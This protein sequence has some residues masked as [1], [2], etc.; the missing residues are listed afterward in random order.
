MAQG[1]ILT[2]PGGRQQVILPGEEIVSNPLN[3]YPTAFDAVEPVNPIEADWQAIQN[4]PITE[5][6]AFNDYLDGGPMPTFSQP[7]VSPITKGATVGALSR[8]VMNPVGLG[9]AAMLYSPKAEGSISSEPGFVPEPEPEPTWFPPT[10]SSGIGGD[11]D[12]QE[13]IG[14]TTPG[15]RRNLVN[16]VTGKV[17]DIGDLPFVPQLIDR[18]QFLPQTPGI[19]EPTEED[20]TWNDSRLGPTL[21]AHKAY[22]AGDR[23][24]NAALG[25]IGIDR[26][27]VH[28][29]EN[30]KI[31]EDLGE[32]KFGRPLSNSEM[33]ALLHI[34]G[35]TT[36]I[37]KNV[38]G[39]YSAF[40]KDDPLSALQD[41][42]NDMVISSE[43]NEGKTIEELFDDPN[44]ITGGE[45]N[46]QW[47]DIR[48]L[49]RSMSL[50]VPM[51]FEGKQLE[52]QY[53][54]MGTNVPFPIS[55]I[56]AV[57]A[58]DSVGFLPAPYL[59]PIGEEP[60]RTEWFGRRSDDVR[61]PY[62][63]TG[64]QAPDYNRMDRVS[65]ALQN[66]GPG[67]SASQEDQ[68]KSAQIIFSE[69]MEDP[70]FH[71]DVTSFGPRAVREAI[72]SRDISR[73][74]TYESPA[75]TG[76]SIATPEGLPANKPFPESVTDLP[77]VETPVAAGPRGMAPRIPPPPEPQPEPAREPARESSKDREAR[78]AREAA[79]KAKT[80]SQTTAA[81]RKRTSTKAKVNKVAKE[82][83]VPKS[84]A[85]EALS[86][87]RG[88][89]NKAIMI[90]PVIHH[91]TEKKKKDP[92]VY[93]P[94]I[95]VGPTGQWI[96]G[97]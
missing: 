71:Q 38:M 21:V 1:E 60:S 75:F 35:G 22:Q 5:R 81:R 91:F 27:K 68:A 24:L 28:R 40:D 77:I 54:Y 14:S 92:T 76:V 19:F 9:L 96:G 8:M 32:A 86:R 43:V 42:I 66:L 26:T 20:W 37:V 25:K 79:K 13:E 51:E 45:D 97:L 85:S 80:Q 15:I 62:P 12:E 88:D 72:R 61:F 46:L 11:V 65:A 16:W 29:A 33:D 83:K 63:E 17:E 7:K 52:P 90:A 94:S 36:P 31:A 69:A 39:L 23:L 18:D 73:L 4:I 56:P 67:S 59:G 84:A 3:L 41:S 44:I 6:Q 95:R 2:Y 57:E 87:A 49:G 93:V 47:S 82:T 58:H 53:P 55:L 10:T 48:N 89:A 70:V 74:P 64:F 30:K 34:A 78:E 50:D